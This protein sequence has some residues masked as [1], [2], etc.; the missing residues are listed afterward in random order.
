[1]LVIR[2]EVS[3]RYNGHGLQ[4]ACEQTSKLI[5]TNRRDE[6]TQSIFEE[7]NESEKAISTHRQ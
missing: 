5:L 7:G 3:I 1:V 2:R 4:S 6:A